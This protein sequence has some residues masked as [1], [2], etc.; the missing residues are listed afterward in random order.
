MRMTSNNLDEKVLLE[1]ISSSLA[2][3][4]IVHVDS[5]VLRRGKEDSEEALQPLTRLLF[6]LVLLHCFDYRYTCD[7]LAVAFAQEGEMRDVIVAHLFEVR[8]PFVVEEG[9]NAEGEAQVGF[10]FS[11]SRHL[12]LACGWLMAVS[13]FFNRSLDL[14]RLKFHAIYKPK[15]L[16]LH[17]LGRK[18]MAAPKALNLHE[19]SPKIDRI[20][21]LAKTLRARNHS[22]ECL[23]QKKEK[24]ISGLRGKLK[25]LE[26][27]LTL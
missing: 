1:Y 16:D 20:S 14:F 3:W 10:D 23:A 27:G 26:G 6:D 2:N 22:V 17:N 4:G 19:G 9:E 25:Q 12:L 7:Q 21:F 18:Y 24:M 8:S 5:R 13:N 15:A 11:S